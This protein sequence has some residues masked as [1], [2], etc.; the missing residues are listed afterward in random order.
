MTQRK[1]EPGPG[2]RV[3]R[4]AGRAPVR[5]LEPRMAR[6]RCVIAPFMPS[7]V[8]LMAPRG[9][10]AGKLRVPVGRIAR[11][12]PYA[13]LFAL[14]LGLVACDGGIP[15]VPGGDA[16]AARAA[17]AVESG[18][19][20]LGD[21]LRDVNSPETRATAQAVA[22]AAAETARS[23]AARSRDVARAAASPEARERAEAAFDR[24]RSGA[25]AAKTRVEEFWGA[26]PPSVQDAVT[27][28]VDR[29][30]AGSRAIAADAAAAVAERIGSRVD[31]VVDRIVVEAVASAMASGGLT[32]EERALIAALNAAQDASAISVEI[33]LEEMGTM[34]TEMDQDELTALLTDIA[35]ETGTATIDRVIADFYQ[36]ELNL[37]NPPVLVSQL[38]AIAID[39]FTETLLRQIV[40]DALLEMEAE[41][42]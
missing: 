37:I 29:A 42:P 14:L 10:A 41:Q 2:N 19:E 3:S 7:L 8:L 32:D 22:R 12:R 35:H 11:L 34:A 27:G 15:A 6:I 5:H 23:A 31:D 40:V 21:R 13:V 39:E 24:A 33:A 17:Q 28:V 1:L 16:V 20:Q 25:A 38:A 9:G 18:R 4:R 26:T 30:L 36:R